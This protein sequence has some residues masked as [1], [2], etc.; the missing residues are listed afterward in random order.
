MRTVLGGLLVGFAVGGCGGE[1]GMFSTYTVGDSAGIQVVESTGAVWGAA[2][3]WSVGAQPTTRIGS[4]EGADAY[5]FHRIASATRL[6]DGRIVVVDAGSGQVRLFGPDGTHE[7]TIGALGDGPGEFRSIRS[8]DAGGDSVVVFDD[9]LSRV[10][11]YRLSG[12]LVT[13]WNVDLASGAVPM[14][15]AEVKFLETGQVVGMDGMSLAAG[16]RPS[17]VRDTAFLFEIREG[18]P[19]PEAIAAVPG[20]WTEFVEL[21]G[22][23]SFRHQ[24][25]TS[26]PS[27]DT[28]AG[29][30]YTTA[31]DGF[32]FRV[33]GAS[34]EVTRI[35]RRAQASPPVTPTDAQA[36]KD[37]LLAPA[38]EAQRAMMAPMLEAFHMPATLPVY[39]TL[40][41]DADGNV[42]LG[43]FVAP[44]IAPPSAWDVYTPDGGYLGVVQTPPGLR[45]FEIGADHVLGRWTDELD[46]EY[47][48]IHPLERTSGE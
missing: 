39:A 19:S 2:P 36:W 15:M 47:V 1:G 24:A 44:G 34:G 23:L 8:V 17:L 14:A 48:Q 11:V 4:V 20:A 29:S 13:T 33:H 10:T 18:L 37:A 43:R 12:E 5:R 28:H 9:R 22:Q 6:P 41:V 3:A 27:W 32:E 26:L 16:S 35:V 46:V 25:L 45:V 38:P 30:I 31:G 7:S 40:I 42:W 21:G